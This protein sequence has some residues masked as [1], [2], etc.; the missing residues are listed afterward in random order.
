VYVGRASFYLYPGPAVTVTLE[1]G[2]A[3]TYT[4]RAIPGRS[5]AKILKS[6]GGPAD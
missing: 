2:G 1:V 4:L 5:R 6:L 3:D